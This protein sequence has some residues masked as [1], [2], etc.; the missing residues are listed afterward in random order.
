MN[1]PTSERKYKGARRRPW[2]KWVSEIRV[3][4]TRERLWLGSYSTPEAA[5]VAHD[6]AVFFLH[7]PGAPCGLNFPDRVAGLA[8]ASLS[9]TSVQRVASESGMDVDAQLVVLTSPQTAAAQPVEPVEPEMLDEARQEA[10]RGSRIGR[11]REEIIG[12]AC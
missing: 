11:Q 5:A 4:G 8:W 1:P 9:P 10:I 3:P 2:G 6:T 12:D 7:G